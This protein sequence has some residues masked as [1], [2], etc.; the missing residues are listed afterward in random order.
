MNGMCIRPCDKALVSGGPG[1]T[2]PPRA[3]E[4]LEIFNVGSQSHSPATVL[5]PWGLAVLQMLPRSG[6]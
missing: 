2:S 6:S 5:C 4:A 3:Y 1:D